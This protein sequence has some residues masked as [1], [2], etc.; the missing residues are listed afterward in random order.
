MTK[1]TSQADKSANTWA[2]LEPVER[3]QAFFALLDRDA[4]DSLAAW[5]WRSRPSAP[6]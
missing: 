3:Y 5:S 1:A 6:N 4:R 2:G